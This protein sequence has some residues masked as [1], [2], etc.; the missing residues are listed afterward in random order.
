MSEPLT[1]LKIGEAIALALL[2][3]KAGQVYNEIVGESDLAELQ[4]NTIAEMAK[5]TRQVI[6]D[7]FALERIGTAHDSIR[8]LQRHMHEYTNAPSDDRL[9]FA[10]DES[11]RLVAALENEALGLLAH[12]VYM[13][14]ACLRIA[15][16]QEREKRYGGGEALNTADSARIYYKHGRQ[17]NQRFAEWL[18]SRLSDVFVD[19]DKGY[20]RYCFT[21]FEER[22]CEYVGL[23][24]VLEDG[25]L[26]DPLNHG[27]AKAAAEQWRL[28]VRSEKL[29][30]LADAHVVP[31]MNTLNTLGIMIKQYST[32]GRGV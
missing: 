3:K 21:W 6:S 7:A 12:P 4:R 19:R 5:L 10:T 24:T 26:R 25:S 30:V 13:T 27:E 8:M 29:T 1:L 16:L 9:S 2:Q 14:A 17:L 28:A 11:Q 22:N 15:V 31:V 18:G 32:R 20:D 23:P